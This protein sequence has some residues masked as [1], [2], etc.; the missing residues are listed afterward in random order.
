MFTRWRR[1]ENVRFQ[2][3]LRNWTLAHS[4]TLDSGDHEWYE[5]ARVRVQCSLKPDASRAIHEI[6]VRAFTTCRDTTQIDTNLV[7]GRAARFAAQIRT[8]AARSRTNSKSSP[9][10]NLNLPKKKRER[11]RN[12]DGVN[13]NSIPWLVENVFKNPKES[14]G[15][16][17][18]KTIDR[19]V[20]IFRRE[21]LCC[22]PSKPAIALTN[23]TSTMGTYGWYCCIFS[24]VRKPCFSPLQPRFQW[25]AR[26]LFLENPANFSGPKSLLSNCNPLV[27]KS[28]KI[29]LRGLRSLMD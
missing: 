28:C 16:Y 20:C 22:F 17:I 6:R 24:T 27:L 4:R 29:K 9:R 10:T 8:E 23:P 2:E 18:V 12:Y 7:L 1:N 21:L 3:Y 11:E 15:S 19:L 14:L 26:D 5:I 13:K 25:K